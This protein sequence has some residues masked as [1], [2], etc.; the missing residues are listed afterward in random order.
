MG[1][2]HVNEQ[3]PDYWQ[4]K[5]LKADYCFHDVFSRNLK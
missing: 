5:F 1:Q 3:W 2:N 4:R